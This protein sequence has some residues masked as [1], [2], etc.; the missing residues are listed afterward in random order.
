MAEATTTRRALMGAI[1]TLPAAIAFD[2]PSAALA[3]STNQWDSALADYRAKRLYCDNLPYGHPNED[4]A[5]DAYCA[6]MDI[7]I[8]EVPAPTPEAWKLKVELALERYEG[9]EL[10]ER[11]GRAIIADGLRL[12]GREAL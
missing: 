3:T 8:E 11:C 5:V 9:F 4:D 10:S 2:P 7:L 12:M 6:A 1:A